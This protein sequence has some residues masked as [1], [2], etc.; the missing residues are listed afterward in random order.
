MKNHYVSHNNKN[1]FVCYNNLVIIIINSPLTF[2]TTLSIS[3]VSTISLLWSLII[4][5]LNLLNVIK[6]FI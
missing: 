4:G 1:G 5:L 6:H 2:D 3:S